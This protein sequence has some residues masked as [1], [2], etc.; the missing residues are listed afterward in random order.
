MNKAQKEILKDI[1]M[2]ERACF[3]NRAGYRKIKEGAHEFESLYYMYTDGAIGLFLKG[4][5]PNGIN[6]GTKTNG[7]CL[8]EKT[9]EIAAKYVQKPSHRFELDIPLTLEKCKQTVEQWRRSADITESEA[10]TLQFSATWNEQTVDACYNADFLECLL[11]LLPPDKTKFF[12]TSEPFVDSRASILVGVPK[13]GKDFAPC[14][15]LLPTK[16][17]KFTKNLSCL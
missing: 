5:V 10:P 2:R 12:V 14:G 15:F 6:E 16:P 1:I 13:D 3:Q 8:L 4:P 11:T 17:D 9:T 7:H